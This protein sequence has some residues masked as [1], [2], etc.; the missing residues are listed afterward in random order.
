MVH[1][2][3]RDGLA[4]GVSRREVYPLGPCYPVE[5]NTWEW[6]GLSG[7]W[8]EQ[9]IGAGV[10]AGGIPWSEPWAVVI[11]AVKHGVGYVGPCHPAQFF[12]A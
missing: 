8:L 9:G 12:G 10:A 11:H 7:Q 5:V 1:L 2:I 4:R 3:K 6:G